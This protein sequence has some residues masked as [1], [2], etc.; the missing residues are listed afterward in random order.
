MQNNALESVPGCNDTQINA[1][2]YCVDINDF[3]YGFTLLPTGGWSGDWHY[4]E[5]L[6]VDLT[7]E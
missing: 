2:D 5:P 6:E 4:S 1:W 7:G 3:D